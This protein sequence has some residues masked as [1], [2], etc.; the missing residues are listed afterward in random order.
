MKKTLKSPPIIGLWL[1]ALVMFAFGLGGTNATAQVRQGGAVAP[2]AVDF[3]RAGGKVNVGLTGGGTVTYDASRYLSW[4]QRFISIGGGRGLSAGVYSTTGYYDIGPSSAIPVGTVIPGVGGATSITTTAAGIPISQWGALYYKLTGA[5]SVFVPANLIFVGFNADYT[6]TPDMVLIASFNSENKSI[7]LGSGQ[8]MTPGTAWSALAPSLGVS[9]T[10]GTPTGASSTQ[11]RTED[12]ADAG[13][14][15]DAGA[16]SGFFQASALAPA[17][18]WYTGA[19]GW[20]HMLDVRHSNPTNNYAM[21]F[22][23]SF[24]DQRFWARKTNN[25]AAQSW[26][27]LVT[28]AANGDIN[29]GFAPRSYATVAAAVADTTLAANSM[30]VVPT[31]GG[32]ALYVK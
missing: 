23:G 28:Q 25:N 21:Q 30:Y 14:R 7:R 5:N 10:W 11:A 32:K 3:Y 18:N 24:Y 31:G 27:Q 26:V 1:M 6:V 29:L 19:T 15:G 13:L 2:A 8:T 4:T 22:A 12:R 16:L 17:A 9:P 20:Q